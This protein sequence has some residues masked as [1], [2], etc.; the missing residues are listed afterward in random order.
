[1]KPTKKHI[2]VDDI[3]DKLDRAKAL[4]YVL[5]DAAGGDL[6]VEDE[7]THQVSLMIANELKQAQELLARYEREVEQLRKAKE[8]A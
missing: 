4:A 8:A 7:N 1:M 6:N 5:A 3:T 2:Y